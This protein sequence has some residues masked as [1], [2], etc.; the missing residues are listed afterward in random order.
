M[1]DEARKWRWDLDD[2]L[3]GFDLDDRLVSLDGTSDGYQPADDL[4]LG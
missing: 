1:N 4:G 3:V 2:C